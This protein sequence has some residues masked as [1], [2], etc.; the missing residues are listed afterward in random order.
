MMGPVLIDLPGLDTKLARFLHRQGRLDV[1][2]LRSVLGETRATR[3]RT[4]CTLARE[5]V[6]RGVLEETEAAD[7]IA[8]LAAPATRDDPLAQSLAE[9]AEGAERPA[10]AE[11]EG[12]AMSFT[13]VASGKSDTIVG[14]ATPGEPDDP[15][16]WQPG[17]RIKDHRILRKLGVGGM[18][19]VFLAEDTRTGARHAIKTMLAKA[20]AESIARFL[21]E[22]E[23]HASVD[24]HPNVVRVHSTGNALGRH[25]LVMDLASGGDLEDRLKKGPL[26]PDEAA[27]I[28]RDLA[29]GLAYMHSKSI[30][31]RD[32]KPANVLFD[33]AGVPK[34]VDFGIALVQGASRLTASGDSIGTP[35]YMAPEQVLARRELLGPWT[36]VYGLGGI[37]YFALTGEHPYR[38][39]SALEIMNKVVAGNLVAPQNLRPSVPEELDAICR[40]ALAKNHDERPTAPE[41]AAA[42][43]GYLRSQSRKAA[44]KRL[45]RRARPLFVVALAVAGLGGLAT[46]RA[47]RGAPGPVEPTGRVADPP[48]RRTPGAR[49]LAPSAPPKPEPVATGAAALAWRW[50]AGQVSSASLTA[51]TSWTLARNL[52]INMFRRLNL[53][54]RAERV[55]P[56]LVT[57][58]ATVEG[59]EFR[60]VVQ[61]EV[62]LPPAMR[63]FL[64]P[65]AFDSA[66]AEDA[67][68][69][70]AKAVG[71]SFSLDLDPRTGA[72]TGVRGVAAINSAVM[73]EV[74]EARLRPRYRVPELAGD[75]EMLETLNALFHL[76]PDHE[77]GAARSSWSLVLP[78][79]A[80]LSRHGDLSI[81]GLFTSREAPDAGLLVSWSG[82][83]GVEIKRTLAGSATFARGRVQRV[84]LREEATNPEGSGVTTYDFA[85]APGR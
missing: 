74:P 1:G 9:S 77:D 47:R 45:R 53:S 41:L 13:V 46:I 62:E 24:A 83:T 20:D 18:G 43:G 7:C 65:L 70:L 5:L 67:R 34:L 85:E 61:T 50:E 33:E 52:T 29:G 23:A 15:G 57:V 69:P 56:S 84:A 79:S 19:I 4:G 72:V 31:H 44:T 30:L 64:Q 60:Y 40:R 25:Y 49:P 8:R 42:L 51:S 3:T 11:P 71:A 68:N 38:G 66:R 22:G 80:A 27:A 48:G 35:A 59:L 82:S 81:R 73:F 37:L 26:D 36:D 16:D 78:A 21:R 39:T 14:S 32:L 58:A 28:V 63:D 75:R 54:W 76:A 6:R 12:A 17:T 10:P 2:L 55:E